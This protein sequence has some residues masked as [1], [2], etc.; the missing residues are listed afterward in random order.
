[1]SGSIWSQS[2]NFSWW[3]LCVEILGYEGS[4]LSP[5]FRFFSFIFPQVPECMLGSFVEEC[6][7]SIV[8][9][10]LGESLDEHEKLWTKR[11]A[12]EAQKR[13]WYGLHPFVL[14]LNVHI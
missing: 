10:S 8:R 11:Q 1:M 14:T 13:I 3:S 2:S 4:S 12:V 6:G 9:R 7:A 5:E